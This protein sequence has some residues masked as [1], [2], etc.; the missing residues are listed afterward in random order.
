MNSFTQMHNDYLDPDRAGLNDVHPSNEW[1]AAAFPNADGP[2]ELYRQTY[3]YTACGPSLGVTFLYTQEATDL[4][5]GPNSQCFDQEKSKTLYCDELYKLGTWKDM[6][7]RGELVVGFLVSSIVEGVDYD[8]QTVGLTLDV[9]DGS[10]Q[11]DGKDFTMPEANDS[12]NNLA[13]AFDAAV[14]KVSDEAQEIRDDTHGCESCVRHWKRSGVTT[15]EYGNNLA[16]GCC[17]IWTKCRSCKGQG[18]II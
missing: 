11:I 5:A 17:P 13:F 16:V 18:T 9:E 1:I 6:D 8:C 14:Q 7:S 2:G 10:V 15:D 4:E 3:K 12:S